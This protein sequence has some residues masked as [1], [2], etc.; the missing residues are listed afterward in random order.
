ML[1]KISEEE[2]ESGVRELKAAFS[3]GEILL[4]IAKY[5]FVWARK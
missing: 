1:H 5:T 3:S 2:Y 4:Y